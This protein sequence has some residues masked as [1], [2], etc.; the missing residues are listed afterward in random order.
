MQRDK[1]YLIEFSKGICIC[2][3]GFKW[4]QN[5]SQNHSRVTIKIDVKELS[6]ISK[7]VYFG[8]DETF[9]SCK[10]SF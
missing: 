5:S 10:V 7:F 9:T 6:P 2:H 8:T 1:E 3:M 4:S